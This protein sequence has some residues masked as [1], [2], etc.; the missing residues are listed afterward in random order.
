[1]E[2]IRTE[3][4]TPKLLDP[5]GYFDG[6][7]SEP[8]LLVMRLWATKLQPVMSPTDFMLSYYEVLQDLAALRT[9]NPDAFRLLFALYPRLLP[10]LLDDRAAELQELWSKTMHEVGGQLV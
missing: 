7:L 10:F 1:M 4:I 8:V 5:Y 6:L 3:T 9:S 2:D